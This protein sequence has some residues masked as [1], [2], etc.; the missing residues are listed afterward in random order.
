MNITPSAPREILPS[1]ALE[2]I[3]LYQS[4]AASQFIIYGNVDDRL[5]LP[6]GNSTRVGGLHDFLLQALMPRFDVVLGYDIGNGIRIERGGELFSQWPAFRK[7]PDLP[8]APRPAIETLTRYFRYC[9]NLGRLGKN[10]PQVGCIIKAV[11]L[12]APALPGAFHYDLNAL[13]ML[14]REWGTD[15]LLVE[16]PLATCLICE[17]LH[18]VHPLLSNNPRAAA[19]KIPLPTAAS[20]EA[21]LGHLASAFPNALCEFRGNLGEAAGQL[22]GAT[23]TSVE[24]LLKLKEHKKERVSRQDLVA[25]KKQLVENECNGLVE[26][27]ESKRSLDHLHGQEKLKAW[28]RQDIALW[29]AGDHQALPMGYLICG[30]VG[31]GKTY[32]V[33]CLAGEAGVPVVKIKNFRDKWVGSTEGNLERIFRLLQA[34]GR[35]FVFIDEADQALGRRDSGS[36]D[37][38]LSGRIYSMIAAEMSNPANRGRIIWILASS[39]PDLIEVDLKRPGRV[40]VKIPIFPTAS[41]EEGFELLR[42]LCSSRGLLIEKENFPSLRDF[43][44]VWLTP[45]A[46]EALAMKVYRLVKTRGFS[47]PEALQLALKDYQSPVPLEVLQSQ[48]QLAI[49]ETT[50]WE[51]VPPSFRQLEGRERGR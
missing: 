24:N 27:I 45:G 20:M 13:A 35:C 37:A 5:L 39:R 49:K 14:M 17:N 7:E 34:L 6:L 21:A 22:A 36:N 43:I 23:F 32:M 3:S 11:H 50:D 51:F 9:A 38:G 46:A 1:W 41:P 19:V 18:D 8:K 10:P 47:P 30:P 15:D 33:E 40:D 2:I 44:P 12:V 26:F 28:L 31:T 29:Q 25:I 16:S 42:A 4:H 48:M